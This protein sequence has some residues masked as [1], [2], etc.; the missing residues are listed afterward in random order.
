M[1]YIILFFIL[2][3][4]LIAKVTNE[5]ITNIIRK[6]ESQYQADT[7]FA[8]MQMNIKKES[9]KRSITMHSWGKGRDRFLTKIVKPKKEKGIASL[10]I[11]KNI[12]NYL[13]KIDRIIKIPSSLMGDS[14]M[15][16]HFTNDDLVKAD[17]IDESYTFKVI[18]NNNKIAI[19]ESIP[20]NDAAV[21]WGKIIYH[22]DIEKEVAIKIEYFDEDQELVRTMTLDNIKFIQ[23][24]YIPT[25]LMIFP[26]E[27]KNEFTE[28]I[29]QKLQLNIPLKKVKFSVRYLKKR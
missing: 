16:S 22:L 8:I 2:N 10:K 17:K 29:Y 14:W 7:S 11:K 4:F 13:P 12:W 15:G 5:Y 1:K 21:V 27:N 26:N 20:K 3:S 25:H 9:W 18:N 23:G 28:I 19:V 6:V 24:R